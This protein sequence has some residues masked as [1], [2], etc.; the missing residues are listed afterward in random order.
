[1]SI[2]ISNNGRGAHDQVRRKAVVG[3]SP[4]YIIIHSKL[5]TGL[6]SCTI[7]TSITGDLAACMWLWLWSTG[8]PHFC[9]I[10]YDWL[11]GFTKSRG[12]VRSLKFSQ[13]V[14]AIK[15]SWGYHDQGLMYARMV[16][17]AHTHVCNPGLSC[18]ELTNGKTDG[19]KK[20]STSDHD[21]RCP[22][23]D[24]HFFLSLCHAAKLGIWL[25]SINQL[26]S[27]YFR[28]RISKNHGIRPTPDLQ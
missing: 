14:H 1:M 11:P 23:D 17:D 18:P 7:A 28:K 27:Q 10:R 8:S 19:R 26:L 21:Q 12:C 2:C 16:D 4:N 5:F 24:S 20:R 13:L 25:L 9:V 15:S 22:K 3:I 6:T